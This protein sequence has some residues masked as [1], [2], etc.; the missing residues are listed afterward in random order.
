MAENNIYRL[1]N[2][3]NEER[4]RRLKNDDTRDI[5]EGK[6]LS[7]AEYTIKL[8][9]DNKGAPKKIKN[10][11]DIN[12]IIINSNH[13]H[14]NIIQLDPPK[15]KTKNDS[16]DDDE[17]VKRKVNRDAQ[18]DDDIISDP[19]VFGGVNG[20]IDN[21]LALWKTFK[22]KNYAAIYNMS[23]QVRTPD[24]LAGLKRLGGAFMHDP[25]YRIQTVRFVKGT[26]HKGDEAVSNT[27]STC[28]YVDRKFLEKRNKLDS[29][30][31]AVEYC[32]DAY[33]G[34]DY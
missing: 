23:E 27:M 17:P 34:S 32:P 11:N 24:M 10:T 29:I 20:M 6:F 22:P 16:S 8:N 14:A 4:R 28:S 7:K 2:I 31:Y 13:S 33:N 5:N 15:N 25:G 19:A 21:G 30:E 18:E 3:R 9:L 26:D 1:R 12:N